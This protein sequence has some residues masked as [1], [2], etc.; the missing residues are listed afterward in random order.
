[1][2]TDFLPEP[3]RIQPLAGQF[4]IPQDGTIGLSHRSLYPVARLARKMLRHHRTVTDLPEKKSTLNIRLGKTQRRPGY[5][6]EINEEGVTLVA[7]T[8]QAAFWGAKT[9]LQ[10]HRQHG[11]GVL[12]NMLIEDWPDFPDRGIY[13]DVTRGRVPRIGRLQHMA[14]TLAD[15][16]INQLQPYIEHVFR[17][18]RHPL[19]GRG[20]SP[21]TP[22]D[23]L[24]LQKTCRGVHIELLPSLASFGHMTTVL[25]HQPYRHLA[26]DLG[27]GE[28]EC[29]EGDV[30]T[31]LAN[32][33]TIS[34]AEPESYDFL[35]SL[36]EEFL[37]LFD[38]KRFNV[39]CDETVD[40][41]L[42][43]SYS[44]CEEKGRGRVYLDHILR[45]RELA[46]EQGKR[47][48][49]WADVINQYPDLIDE[50][51]DDA[52]VLDWGYAHDFDFDR[53]RKFT[54]AGLSAYGCPGTSSWRS[55]FPRLHESR[56]NITGY[57]DAA[58][59]HGAR[60]LLITDWGGGGHYNFQEY[61]WYGYLLGAEQAWN[62]DA[63]TETFTRRF[64]RLFMN[65]EDEAFAD[66]VELLGDIS[67]LQF[68]T[69]YQSIWQHV[70]FA[71]PE[72]QVL[73]HEPDLAYVCRQGEISHEDFTL[74]ATTGA[75]A[76]EKLED[77]KARLSRGTSPT[78]ADPHEVMPY[79]L[80]AVDTLRH[81]ARKLSL[82]GPG[83]KGNATDRRTLRDEMESLRARFRTLWHERNRPSEIGITLR[84]YDRVIESL[85][86]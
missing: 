70:Y 52:T 55:L 9:L 73:N 32:G 13:Y 22:E 1:M 69:Y 57:A 35:Q 23:I 68:A 5:R 3:H 29:P 46:R 83:G 37:P 78:D 20:A 76:L 40:L 48:M 15:F 53:I 63:D 49:F 39:C 72:D 41:G 18:R 42:G 61:S 45:L 25:Q 54:D 8:V 2:N 67:H 75:V 66:A 74:D 60:G 58:R 4:H 24:R 80:F 62:V 81:A 33:W 82:L 47:I 16:K 50:I 28:Y 10:I 86:D 84:R 26:E 12:P 38:S 51:P 59:R 14:R 65:V 7:D 21:L 30:P 77:V 19:I 11:E 6:L 17:F 71:T 36:Y 43:Q 34:P 27:V 31:D 85:A 44:M 79:W 64:C 56:A